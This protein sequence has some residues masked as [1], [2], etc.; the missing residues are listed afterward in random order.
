MA[1][2]MVSIVEFVDD[3]HETLEIC[4]HQLEHKRPSRI[5]L[6]FKRLVGR[7]RLAHHF[8]SATKSYCVWS[9]LGWDEQKYLDNAADYF[10]F[11]SIMERLNLRQHL[12]TLSQVMEI[13]FSKGTWNGSNW[14]ICNIWGLNRSDLCRRSKR[15]LIKIRPKNV[16]LAKVNTII[17]W[18]MADWSRVIMSAS[19]GLCNIWNVDRAF[20]WLAVPISGTWTPP[21]YL[22]S[23]LITSHLTPQPPLLRQISIFFYNPKNWEEVK[24]TRS[25]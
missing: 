21:R 2:V 11:T 18:M 25:R 22:Y 15:F 16:R 14:M 7:F 12:L 20:L 19:R 1:G 13:Q 23:K 10:N 6:E 8:I 24:V 4:D 17:V 5:N 9:R 3:H